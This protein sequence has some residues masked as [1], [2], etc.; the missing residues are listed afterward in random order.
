M[1]LIIGLLEALAPNN[2]FIGGIV[3]ELCTCTMHSN[4]YF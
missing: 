3:V 1:R 2:R 4:A